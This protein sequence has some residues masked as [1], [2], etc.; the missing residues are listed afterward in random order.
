[1][2]RSQ[3][4]FLTYFLHAIGHALLVKLELMGL[5]LVHK[6]EVEGEAHDITL[7]SIIAFILVVINNVKITVLE[8]G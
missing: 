5:P 7:Y 4:A 8:G 2:T 1:M 3:E 6:G